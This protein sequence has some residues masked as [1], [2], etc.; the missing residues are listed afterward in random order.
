MKCANSSSVASARFIGSLLQRAVDLLALADADG[1]VDLVGA[2]PPAVAGREDHEPERVR[3]EVDD[4]V[5]LAH[6]P[7]TTRRAR[8]PR[9]AAVVV[10]IYRD[11]SLLSVTVD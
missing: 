2:L 10:L 4:G 11:I 9:C 1:L 8:R 5:A 6:R 3:P 7:E